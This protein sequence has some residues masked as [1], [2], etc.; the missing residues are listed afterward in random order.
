MEGIMEKLNKTAKQDKFRKKEDLDKETKYPVI[1]LNKVNTQYGEALLV[2]LYD[3]NE[4]E[5]FKIWLPQRFAESLSE[6]EIDLINSLTSKP[7]L[8]YKCQ[9]QNDSKPCFNFTY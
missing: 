4:S 5:F 6:N 9:H 8:T 1:K 2:E 3:N 7:S